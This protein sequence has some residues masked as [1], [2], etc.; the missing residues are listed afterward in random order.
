MIHSTEL[1]L[2]KKKTENLLSYSCS[3][4]PGED[5]Y[6]YLQLGDLDLYCK[7]NNRE[8]TLKLLSTIRNVGILEENMINEQCIDTLLN[9]LPLPHQPCVAIHDEYECQKDLYFT[10]FVQP[11][12]TYTYLNE[13]IPHYKYSWY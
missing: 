13:Y 4:P 8:V 12:I 5:I 10:S 1:T 6:Q 2:F 9:M 11:T 7:V 3:L